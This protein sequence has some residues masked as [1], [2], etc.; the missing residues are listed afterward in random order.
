MKKNY[1]C[2]FLLLCAC[3]FYS[4]SKENSTESNYSKYEGTWLWYR[5]VGGFAPRVI[6]PK[7]GTTIKIRF[8][9]FGFFKKF[10]NDSL[11]VCAKYSF[12]KAEWDCYDRIV[13]TDIVTFN[14]TFN[15]DYDH[16]QLTTDTLMIWDGAFDGYSSWYKKID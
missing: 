10:R 5:T 2:A 4:C 3:V 13:Y 15:A 6:T 9:R 7:E 11:K 12:E 16:A 1:L 8:D 14:Y